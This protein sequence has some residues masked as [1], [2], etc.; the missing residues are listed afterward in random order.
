MLLGVNQ[1]SVIVC[2][3]KSVIGC[4]SKNVIGC[5]SKI[6]D[7]LGSKEGHARACLYAFHRQAFLV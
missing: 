4:E 5:E 1:K 7:A 3:S 2:E 6:P